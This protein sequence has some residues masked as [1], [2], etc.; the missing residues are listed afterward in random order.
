[1]NLFSS[2]Y[3][4]FSRVIFS[5]DSLVGSGLFFQSQRLI[6]RAP[7]SA[8]RIYVLV[9]ARLAAWL[10]TSA[11]VAVAL[12][13]AS[14]EPAAASGVYQ[15]IAVDEQKIEAIDHINF[16]NH[17]LHFGVL[18]YPFDPY[19]NS[20]GVA[21]GYTQ[22][23]G[24]SFSWNLLDLNYFINFQSKLTAD[25]ANLYTEKPTYI[26]HVN[27]LLSS[28]FSYHFLFGKMLFF[29]SSL[30][31]L[32]G[33]FLVGGGALNYTHQNVPNILPVLNLGFSLEAFLTDAFSFKL[34]VRDSMGSIGNF[35]MFSAETGFN[36]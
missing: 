16:S 5:Q 33:S 36:F 35:L 22:G 13:F 8:A 32:R 19:Y 25:L 30:K 4:P 14:L 11:V 2:Y 10:K 7:T 27:Y 17:S 21:V 24:E 28:N 34:G 15:K 20:L 26:Q 1:M 9:G 29:R 18:S 12:V 3:K 6:K 31:Y 23:L